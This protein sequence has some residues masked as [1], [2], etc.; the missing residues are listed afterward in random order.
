[1]ETFSLNTVSK[2][3]KLTEAKS[4]FSQSNRTQEKY[5]IQK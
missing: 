3:T 2:K 4:S 5:M 1:M